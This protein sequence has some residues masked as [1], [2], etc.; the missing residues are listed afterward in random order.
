MEQLPNEMIYEICKNADANQLLELLR[1]KRLN[2]AIKDSP[3]IDKL[4]VNISK[5]H[6][7]EILMETERKYRY[8]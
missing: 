3:L 5:P 1:I 8:G 2:Q 7:Q 6:D 4:T